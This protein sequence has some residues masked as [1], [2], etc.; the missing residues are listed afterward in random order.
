MVVVVVVVVVV[1]VVGTASYTIS[2]SSDTILKRPPHPIQ[3]N[4]EV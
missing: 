4:D 2:K 3:Y 1:I